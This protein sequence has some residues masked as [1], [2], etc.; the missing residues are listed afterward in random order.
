MPH[1]IGLLRRNNIG[2]SSKIND[3]LASTPILGVEKAAVR[4]S[5]AAKRQLYDAVYKHHPRDSQ[6]YYYQVLSYAPVVPLCLHFTPFLARVAVI[7]I[8]PASP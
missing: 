5:R 3:I 8:P 2:F 6:C 1:Y 7:L 4:S